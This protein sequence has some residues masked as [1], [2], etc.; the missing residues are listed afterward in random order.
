MVDADLSSRGRP[1]ALGP[2]RPQPLRNG[3]YDRGDL[4]DLRTVV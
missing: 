4:S 2:T 1:A 3:Y